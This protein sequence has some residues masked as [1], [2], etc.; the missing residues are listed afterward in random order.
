MGLNSRDFSILDPSKVPNYE[1]V[2]IYADPKAGKTRLAT[3]LPEEWGDIIYIG[4]DAGSEQLRS[5]L[6]QYQSRII[7]IKPKRR[8]AAEPDVNP[9][10]GA[11]AIAMHNWKETYPKMGVL[12]WDTITATSRTMLQHVAD[13]E[14]FSKRHVKFETPDGV[15]SIP[16]EGDYGGVQEQMDRLTDILLTKPYHVIVLAHKGLQTVKSG[17]DTIV[18]GGGALTVGKATISSFA[19]KFNPVFHMITENKPSIGKNPATTDYIVL[20][21]TRGHYKAGVRQGKKP[22]NP[23]AR[24]V[25][26]EDPV[27]FWNDYIENFR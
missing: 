13:T 7:P 15:V 23:F 3:S 21:E 5:V 26:Q 10:A 20:G 16:M 27:H 22:G 4:A 6:P 18:T 14:Q 12:V 11:F 19:G 24:V 1:K 2:L 25:L 17:E 9:V 8:S